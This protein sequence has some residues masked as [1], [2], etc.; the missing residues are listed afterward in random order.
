MAG[1]TNLMA[2]PLDIPRVTT[3]VAGGNAASFSVIKDAAQTTSKEASNGN[4][5]INKNFSLFILPPI[6]KDFQNNALIN[7]VL[8]PH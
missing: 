1:L 6:F 7:S 4:A 8:G 5:S 3:F 2:G